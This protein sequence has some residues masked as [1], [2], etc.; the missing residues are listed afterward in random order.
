[1]KHVG[2]S[3]LM[4]EALEQVQDLGLQGHVEGRHWLVQDDEAQAQE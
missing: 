4:L 1:M 2:E 3:G